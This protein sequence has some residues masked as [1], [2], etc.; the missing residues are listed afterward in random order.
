MMWLFDASENCSSSSRMVFGIVA[1]LNNMVLGYQ[2]PVRNLVLVRV[3]ACFCW[4][5]ILIY[6]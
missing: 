1:T 4:F 6:S 5:N 2:Y 3:T